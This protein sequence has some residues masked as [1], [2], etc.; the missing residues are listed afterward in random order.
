MSPAATPLLSGPPR[1]TR[2]DRSRWV[3]QCPSGHQ[4]LLNEAGAELL[5]LVAEAPTFL[6]G[7]A[8]FNTRFAT[9]L[10]PGEF[11]SLVQSKFGGYRLLAGEQ[12]P[13]RPAPTTPIRF[14]LQL[15]SPR[16]A[17]ALA[18]P[19]VGLFTPPIFWPLLVALSVALVSGY[20]LA[21]AAFSLPSGAGL[22]GIFYV[23]ILLHE[24][25]HIAACRRAGLAHGGIGVG[26]YLLMPVFYANISAIWQG[27]RHQ[28]IIAN[29]GGIYTQLLFAAAVA[30]VG[31]VAHAPAWL[32]SAQVVAL[33]ALWQLNPFVRHDG[34]WLLADLTNTPNL[35]DQARRVRQRVLSPQLWPALRTG[36]VGELIGPGAGW[37]LTYG[38]VN[39]AVVFTFMG[40]LFWHA[41][42]SILQ[43][44]SL[45]YTLLQ[46]LV[47]GT[48]TKED[49]HA[50]QLTVLVFYGILIRWLIPYVRQAAH[51]WQSARD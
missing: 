33:S 4:V 2:F 45:V 42:P 47:A 24:L 10:T 46:K 5:H 11:Q 22:V 43:L 32:L 51:R 38:L 7:C 49:F 35:L 30:S 29:L 44:P 34:Y 1:L 36:K 12:Q 28:R 9:A 27:S 16:W 21:P 31:L 25:G 8:H 37:L 20:A 40:L 41:A 23:S 48:L 19:L 3:L 15:L 17:G 39:A 13:Q 14:K 18:R 50:K 26:F 6:A